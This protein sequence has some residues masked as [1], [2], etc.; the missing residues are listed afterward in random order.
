[1]LH[2]LAE[3]GEGAARRQ[4]FVTNLKALNTFDKT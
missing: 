2:H 3:A 4:T 1:M